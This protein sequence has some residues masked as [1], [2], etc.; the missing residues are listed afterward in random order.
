MTPVRWTQ[1]LALVGALALGSGCTTLST[2]KA[3][4]AQGV[5]F[6]ARDR[7][8]VR[9]RPDDACAPPSPLRELGDRA[10][11]PNPRPTRHATTR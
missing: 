6:D 2:G 8:V 9:P 1:V 10:H 11:S 3:D 5:A 4:R 7:V